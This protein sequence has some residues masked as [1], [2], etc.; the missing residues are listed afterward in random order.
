MA[1]K[2]WKVFKL[3]RGFVFSAFTTIFVYSHNNLLP[4]TCNTMLHLPI[5]TIPYPPYV[6]SA[7]VD[8][9]VFG[10]L[11]IALNFEIGIILHYAFVSKGHKF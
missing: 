10:L 2:S 7:V 9:N 11:E 1:S 3:F 5:K 6:L 8:F 4:F